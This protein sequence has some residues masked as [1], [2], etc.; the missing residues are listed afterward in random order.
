MTARIIPLH[1]DRDPTAR[2]AQ[3]TGVTGSRRARPAVATLA[4][5]PYRSPASAWR[6]RRRRSRPGTVLVTVV[7]T[8]VLVGG[9]AVTHHVMAPKPAPAPSSTPAAPALVP[10]GGGRVDWQLMQGVWFPTSTL[11]GPTRS[12]RITVSGF[13]ATN[14]GAALAAVHIVYRAS[15]APGPAVFTAALHEQVTGPAA[16]TLT[17]TVQAD[18]ER[19]REGAG[20]SDGTALGDGSATFLG[21]RVTPLS[22]GNRAV[23]VVEQARD[24]T[25]DARLTAFDVV[26]T[27]GTTTVGSS[28]DWKV[29]APTHGTWASAFTQLPQVP[30]DL[31]RFSPAAPAT[32]DAATPEEGD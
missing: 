15:A 8:A 26:L 23:R 13:S 25:G 6:V 32:P 24:E 1:P 12:D 17:T 9:V 30:A 19:A 22:N 20:L 2:H 4:D 31:V 7:L 29:V 27:Y 3:H 10:S 11:D 21:Y 28:A 16:A 14:L 5:D 18:Y